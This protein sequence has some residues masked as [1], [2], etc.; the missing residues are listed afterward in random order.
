MF[1]SINEHL[2]VVATFVSLAILVAVY[3]AFKFRIDF[4]WL[5]FWYSLPFIGK[6]ARLSSDTTRYAKDKTWTNAERTLCED[7]KQ[8][9]HFTGEAELTKRLVYLA[10][11]N[12]LGRKPL[13]AW[14]VFVLGLLVIAEGLGFSYLLGSWMAMEGSENTRTLLM[15]AIVLVLCVILVFVTHSAG[16]QLYRTNLI[17]ASAKDWRDAGQPGSFKTANIM[18]NGDQSVD[19]KEAEYTQCVNRVGTSGSYVMVGIAIAVILV[20]AITSTWMRVKHLENEQ[21]QETTQVAAAATSAPASGNPFAGG[22]AL[23]QDVLKPQQDAEQ[24]GRADGRKAVAD[25]GMAAFLMMAFIFVVTQ[26]VGIAAGFKWGFAGKES[27]AA[28]TGTRGFSTYEDYQAFYAPIIQVAQAKLQTL[29]QRLAERGSNIGLDLQKA[30][31]DYLNETQRQRPL[32]TVASEATTA[33]KSALP[34]EKESSATPTLEEAIARFD[35]LKSNQDI[36][37]KYVLGL[38]PA[39]RE[40]L[41]A[42]IKERKA[43]EEAERQMEKAKSDERQLDELF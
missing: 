1:D 35:E 32:G 6:I 15:V 24:K 38:E 27:K 33:A 37:K 34:V 41:T 5:N 36:A 25:E 40:Q 43:R 4:W 14:L 7:Y 10:K 31:D 39:L 17:K 16:H 26:V 20:I 2:N 23:P 11:A 8:Y 28:Y 18:L 13:P 29:Q 12:D 9:I 42:A 3:F 22:L 19:D 30:F 21:T